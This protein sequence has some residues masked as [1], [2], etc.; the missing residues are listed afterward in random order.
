MK[1]TLE[2]NSKS[3]A[4]DLDAGRSIAIPLDF[5]GPQP[6]HFGVQRAT[7]K[8]VEVGDFVGDTDRGGSCNV[9]QL[10]LIPHCNGTH[11]ESVGHI[12]GETI[13]IG[14]LIPE[15]WFVAKLLS[16]RPVNARE[17]SESYRPELEHQD[18]LVTAGAEGEAEDA[19]TSQQ[20]CTIEWSNEKSWVRPKTVKFTVSAVV[21]SDD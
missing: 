15:C 20:S 16:V 19:F 13:A 11:T 2:I 8:T 7:T 5:N 9:D 18:R 10:S 17:T 4:I 6:N 3:Y 12:V 1:L 21:I 14:Q